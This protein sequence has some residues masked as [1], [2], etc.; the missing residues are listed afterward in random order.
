MQNDDPTCERRSEHH[1]IESRTFIGH[2]KENGETKPSMG[3]IE[4]YDR[5]DIAYLACVSKTL[6]SIFES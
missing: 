3:E 6:V 2:T 1:T 5:S 4:L